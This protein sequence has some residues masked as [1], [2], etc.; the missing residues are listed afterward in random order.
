MTNKPGVL[1]GP[2][3][4][5]VISLTSGQ[6]ELELKP[7]GDS[8]RTAEEARRRAQLKFITQRKQELAALVS[9]FARDRDVVTLFENQYVQWHFANDIRPGLPI[10]TAEF[11][12]ELP[13]T[14]GAYLSHAE[15][16]RRIAPKQ[17]F[18]YSGP[19][20]VSYND[21]SGIETVLTATDVS[22]IAELLPVDERWHPT[23][24]ELAAKLEAGINDL[25][26]KIRSKL[27]A[28]NAMSAAS[29]DDSFPPP[30]DFRTS[31]G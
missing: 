7:M 21:S 23:Q 26:G 11:G 9:R 27:G 29:E 28:V 2:T 30:G 24:E 1:S 6:L 8:V 15:V 18:K 5:A 4:D 25:L 3:R 12:G 14:R 20:I 22:N 16:V 13:Y 19:V 31:V 17:S 10:Y